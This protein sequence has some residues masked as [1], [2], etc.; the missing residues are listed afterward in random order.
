MFKFGW[1]GDIDLISHS[2]LTGSWCNLGGTYNPPQNH[3]RGDQEAKDYLAGKY[4]FRTLE[5]EVYSVNPY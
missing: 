2:N 3:I 4:K 5:I 1:G